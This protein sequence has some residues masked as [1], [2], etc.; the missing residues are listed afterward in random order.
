MPKI[1]CA[2]CLSL[3]QAISAQFTLKM[4]V[5]AQNRENNHLFWEFMVVQGRWSWCQS[6]RRMGLPISNLGP[7]S[8]RFWDT[9]TYYLKMANFLYHPFI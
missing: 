7:I 4:C 5:A 9:A 8:H 1:P 3:S 2:G 6:K